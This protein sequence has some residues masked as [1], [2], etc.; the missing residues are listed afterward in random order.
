MV[1]AVAATQDRSVKCARAVNGGAVRCW[2]LEAGGW[3][4]WGRAVLLRSRVGCHSMVRHGGA[5]CG[6][7]WHRIARPRAADRLACLVRIAVLGLGRAGEKAR[8]FARGGGCTHSSQAP[9][10]C[11]RGAGRRGRTPSG[12]CVAPWSCPCQNF[13]R[14][15]HVSFARAKFTSSRAGG[16]RVNHSVHVPTLGGEIG[17]G[18]ASG[19]GLVVQKPITER[20]KGEDTIRIE[21]S[22]W[23]FSEQFIHEL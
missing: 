22:L 15:A 9:A 16:V 4:A 12:S 5:W 1:M 2:R 17:A 21:N 13:A 6:A 7:A 23:F 19:V 20:E 10:V 11:P 14:S 8:L 18:R 3:C